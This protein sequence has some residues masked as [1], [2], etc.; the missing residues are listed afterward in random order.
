[1][2]AIRLAAKFRHACFLRPQMCVVCQKIWCILLYGTVYANVNS[3]KVKILI[4]GQKSLFILLYDIVYANMYGVK[5]KIYIFVSK[6]FVFYCMALYTQ[7]CIF[8]EIALQETVGAVWAHVCV[9]CDRRLYICI[10][11]CKFSQSSLTGVKFHSHRLQDRHTYMGAVCAK[12]C[13]D[14]AL[15]ETVGEVWA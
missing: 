15:Q 8:I 6:F 1:M 12:V 10:R 14:I 5:V 13:K 2:E 9:G 7:M 11:K 3:V 4:F